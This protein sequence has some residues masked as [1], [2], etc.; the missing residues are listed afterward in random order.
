MERKE[1]SKEGKQANLFQKNIP[2]NN[3]DDAAGVGV[4][5]RLDHTLI[6]KLQKH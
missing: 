5:P 2:K 4:L 6:S 1:A 3:L